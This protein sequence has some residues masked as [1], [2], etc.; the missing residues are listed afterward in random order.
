MGDIASVVFARANGVEARRGTRRRRVDMC[1][2]SRADGTRRRGVTR[3]RARARAREDGEEDEMRG[4][5]FVLMCDVYTI[6]RR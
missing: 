2:R 6:T 4:V 1:P 3:E 5:F